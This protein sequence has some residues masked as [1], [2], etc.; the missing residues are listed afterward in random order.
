MNTTKMDKQKLNGTAY[1]LADGRIL[2]IHNENE[3]FI[4]PEIAELLKTAKKVK[5]EIIKLPEDYYRN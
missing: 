2:F 3:D 5:E 4:P 1:K